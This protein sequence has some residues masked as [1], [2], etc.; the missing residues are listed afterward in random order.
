MDEPTRRQFILNAARS[1]LGV[2][3]LPTLGSNIATAAPNPLSGGSA[4]HVIFLNMAGG[5]SHIDTFDLKPNKKAV[6]G[7]VNPLNSSADGIRVSHFLPQTAKVMQHA[8]VINSMSSKQGAHE[9]GQY[10]L[11]RSYSMR[12]TVVHP[13]TGAWVNKFKG[14]KNPEIPGFV[15]IGGSPEQASAGF[16][17]ARYAGV[18]LGRAD[19]GLKNVQRHAEVSEDDFHRRL[20]LAEILNRNFHSTFS[21]PSIDEYDKL[22]EEAIKLMHSQDLKAFDI[23]DESEANKQR[24]GLNHF[25]QGCLL[26]RRLVEH[27]VRYVEVTLGGWDTHYDNFTGVEARCQVL[28]R[29][30]AS[31]INDLAARGLLA[32]TLVVLA[33]EFGRSPEIVAEHKNGRDHHP[34]AYSCVLAGGGVKGGQVY[35]KT[36]SKGLRVKDKT[37]SPSDLNA[38]IAHSLGLPLERRIIAPS[39]RPFTLAH[40]GRALTDIF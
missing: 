13:T 11:H 36:D 14:R 33:T 31:L 34:A 37:V 15:S 2:S 24:Y 8:C 19:E 1:Y 7:P 17:G 21:H 30:Y 29:A 39:G 40:K 9:Q 6:Q 25:G 27:G 32:N 35:G 3:L 5:M 4:E 28:D 26:A 20:A 16:F 18:P 38:T 10:M 23:T 12:G 22:Y